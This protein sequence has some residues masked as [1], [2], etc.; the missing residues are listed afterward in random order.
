MQSGK[1]RFK[2]GPGSG[3]EITSARLRAAR[4]RKLLIP[5]ALADNIVQLRTRLMVRCERSTGTF[6]NLVLL[7]HE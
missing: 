3:R 6:K 1:I 7:E 4:T 2:A 5:A